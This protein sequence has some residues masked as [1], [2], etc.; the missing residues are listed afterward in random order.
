[1]EAKNQN[2]GVAR[3]IVIG[4]KKAVAKK[5]A[6]GELSMAEIAEELNIS[7]ATLL[8]W[9]KRRTA[10]PVRASALVQPGSRLGREKGRLGANVAKECIP[11]PEQQD[12]SPDIVNFPDTRDWFHRESER[13]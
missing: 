13:S 11:I 6:A 10:L 8:S 3:K 7:T 4:S 12:R 2:P 5:K 9:H 1:M